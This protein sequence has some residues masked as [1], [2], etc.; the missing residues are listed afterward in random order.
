M[1]AKVANAS[2]GA[3][4]TSTTLDN[5]IKS[6]PNTLYVVTAGNDGTNNDTSP[7]TPCNP[8]TTPDAANKICVAATD[9][10]DALAGFSNF[11][12]VNVDLAAPGVDIL[13]TVPTTKTVFTDDFETPIAGRWTTNDAGQTGTP[14]WARTTLFSTSPTH[15]I[16]DS[17]AGNYVANQDNWARNTTGF[18][19][20][21]GSQLQGSRPRRRSTPRTAST[22]S[23]SS[24][25]RTPANAASWQQT[26]LF[27]GAGQGRVTADVPAAFNGQTGVFVRFRLDSD[28][29]IQDDGVYVDDVAVKCFISTFDATSYEF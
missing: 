26:F 25:R 4:G 27:N 7:R 2:L 11:G 28:G 18:N 13:S 15:S 14:R 19:L 29:T 17:P 3:A 16:T 21:G 20:T 10:S 6:K 5:A 1:N 8:A 12:A 24:S 9:S 22:T 23:P